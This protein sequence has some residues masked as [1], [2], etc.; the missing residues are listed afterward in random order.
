MVVADRRFA[1][2]SL[3]V[4]VNNTGI[5]K[6]CGRQ[7]TDYNGGTYYYFITRTVMADVT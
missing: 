1:Q 3:E 6:P 5:E 4:L 2:G 7:W